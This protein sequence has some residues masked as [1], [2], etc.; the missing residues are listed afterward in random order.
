MTTIRA[1][2][3][4]DASAIAELGAQL[5]YPAT[6]TEIAARLA[7]IES[8]PNARVFVAENAKGDVVAWLHVGARA[9]LTEDASAEILGLV[10]DEAARGTGV[11]SELLDAA[12]SWARKLGCARLRVRSRVER[13]LAHRFYQ[14]AGFARIKTQAVLAKSLV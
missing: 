3:A 7:G 9:Q 11:G 10:V 2:R 13:E 14:R 5:G 6:R 1:A 8:E 4:Y 12:E